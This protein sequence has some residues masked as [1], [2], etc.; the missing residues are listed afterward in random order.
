MKYKLVC[1]QDPKKLGIEHGNTWDMK[2]FKE[3]LDSCPECQEFA[4]QVADLMATAIKKSK[5]TIDKLRVAF[6]KSCRDD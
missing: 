5:L 1:K 2:K 6:S 3:H 4:A